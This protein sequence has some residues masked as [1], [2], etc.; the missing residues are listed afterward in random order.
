MA[1]L[2]VNGR[3]RGARHGGWQGPVREILARKFRVELVLPI[4]VQEGAALARRHALDG[5]AVVVSAGGDGSANVLAG[6]LLGTDTPLALLPLGTGNDLARE[7]GIPGDV[8]LAAERLLDMQVRPIDVA[9]VNGRCFLTVGGMGLAAHSALLV[10]GLKS[11]GG[12]LRRLVDSIG[13]RA[14]TMASVFNILTS[15]DGTIDFRLSITG[16]DGVLR[17]VE[18]HAHVLFVTNHRTLGAG[19]AL[20]VNASASDGVIE[21]CWVPAGGRATLL[22]NL[23]RMAR[24]AE[25]PADVLTVVR[26]TRATIRTS[27][28]EQFVGDGD[29]LARGDV[30]EVDVLPGALKVVV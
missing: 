7:L 13:G 23:A 24:G 29:L 14:Y 19:L 26:A 16:P 10:S 2:V 6:A 17:Q 1:V 25:V 8:T 28:P 30:F 22:R 3:S 20:P 15:V 18:A 5:A 4:D 27:K 11:R 21:L 12:L 9:R